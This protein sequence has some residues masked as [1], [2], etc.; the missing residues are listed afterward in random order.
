MSSE[1][2]MDRR[3]G[4]SVAIVL[5]P[6]L[7]LSCWLL[8]YAWLAYGR[9]DDSGDGKASLPLLPNRPE[10]DVDAGHC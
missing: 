5:V 1:T 9:A 3:F 6:V 8:G 7:S 2:S 4:A 10:P